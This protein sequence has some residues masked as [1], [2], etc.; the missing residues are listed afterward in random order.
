MNINDYMKKALD[1]AK[2]GGVHLILDGA[3]L[4]KGLVVHSNT[5]I[6]C[7]NK[8]CGLFIAEFLRINR[9]IET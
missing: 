5:T 9:R 3:A 6:E 7:P 4:V 1:E 2:C 8:D